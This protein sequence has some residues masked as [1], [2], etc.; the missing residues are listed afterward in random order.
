MVGSQK[1]A[2]QRVENKNTMDEL[3]IESLSWHISPG[4]IL[5]K[6]TPNYN[7]SRVPIANVN[8]NVEA[9]LPTTVA[10][11]QPLSSQVSAPFVQAFLDK[12]CS[13]SRRSLGSYIL[14]IK[15]SAQ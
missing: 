8:M 4:P 9:I 3:Q 5:K 14:S 13:R 7:Y 1:K 15:G 11:H 10:Y 6:A 12:N 2:K